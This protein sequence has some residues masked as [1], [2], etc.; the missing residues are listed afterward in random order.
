MC[1]LGF[2]FLFCFVLFGCGGC[3]RVRTGGNGKAS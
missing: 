3:A 1:V 2:S